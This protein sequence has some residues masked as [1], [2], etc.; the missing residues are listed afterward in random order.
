MIEGRLLI[1]RTDHKP[2]IYTFAQKSSK[3]TPRQFRQLDYIS[4]FTTQ[5]EHIAGKNNTAADTLSRIEEINMPVIVTT[6]ELAEAQKLDIELEE[7]LKNSQSSLQLKK[8]RLDNTETTVVCDTSGSNI[9]IY[10]PAILR[11]K[12]YDN[13]HNLSHPGGRATR[14]MISSKF[15]WPKMKHDITSW[16]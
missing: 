3:A 15:V 1:V 7:L 5:I 13:V 6:N 14:K 10:V 8:L 4:Q 2:L 9:R 16:A 11:K 12:I